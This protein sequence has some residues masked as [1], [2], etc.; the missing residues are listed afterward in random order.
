MA[1]YGAKVDNFFH[2]KHLGQK[3]ENSN[4]IIMVLNYYIL[5]MIYYI[6]LLYKSNE[7]LDLSQMPIPSSQIIF[8]S[9]I[10]KQKKHLLVAHMGYSLSRDA[11]RRQYTRQRQRTTTQKGINSAGWQP[12][13]RQ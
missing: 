9:L 3:S 1:T 12:Q 6:E 11:Y 7:L 5:S 10:K 8:L 4:S 2:A 13:L